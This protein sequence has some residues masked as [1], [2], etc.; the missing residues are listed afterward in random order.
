MIY[1]YQ[2]GCVQSHVTCLDFGKCDNISEMVQDSDIF[3]ME[4]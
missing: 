2:R 4:D 3:A 1:Y